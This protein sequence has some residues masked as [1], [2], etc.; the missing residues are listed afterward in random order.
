MIGYFYKNVCKVLLLYENLPSFLLKNMVLIVKISKF[1]YRPNK[2]I[3]CL[4]DI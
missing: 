2:L 3:I 4:Q 1:K